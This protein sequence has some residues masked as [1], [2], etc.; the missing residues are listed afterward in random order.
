MKV[1][2]SL[3]SNLRRN[4]LVLFA[5]GLS[6]WA[7]LASL[8]PTLP[9]YI[10]DIGATKQQI[11]VI[12]GS[13]AIGLLLFRPLLGQLADKRGRKIVLIIGLLSAA[14]APIGYNFV[15]S[16]PV[17]FVIRAF[18]G[19]SIAAFSTAF[20]ALVADIAPVENRGELIGYM[21][22]TNP[23]GM[24]IGPAL[25]GYLMETYSYTALF[26][27]STT[28]A[29]FGLLFSLP[30]INPVVEAQEQVI[31]SDSSF[32]LK[33]LAPRIRIPAILLFIIGL[34]LGN[35]HTFVTLFIKSMEVDLN[36]GFFYT[37][38]AMASFC[39]RLFSGKASD[40]FGRGLF[41][42][43]SLMCYTLAML[44]LWNANSSVE[45]LLAATVQGIGGGTIIPMISAMI[46]DRSYSYERGRTFGLCMI[47]FDIGVAIA[48]PIF[49]GIAQQIGYRNIFGFNSGITLIAI[50]IFITLS[51][52]NLPSSLRFAFGRGVDIYSVN[53]V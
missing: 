38:V 12:M 25:G 18:H 33:L 22:L 31:N 21:S 34:T 14:I 42:T 41:I 5:A 26:T 40:R 2:F 50:V 29:C 49:G 32:W 4:L 13:F 19:I 3:D 30:I 6:F 27:L 17:L 36:P 43:S 1:L 48:G 53:K 8:L 52:K 16:I 9:L 37:V 44:I 20:L 35:L 11:G 23:I 47:G 10:E 24:A 46:T 28:L 7:S 45:F 51:S 15:Q 39:S